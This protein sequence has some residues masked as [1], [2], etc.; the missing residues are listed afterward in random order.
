MSNN[1]TVGSV[2]K[3]FRKHLV[4]IFVITSVISIFAVIG[5]NFVYSRDG[6]IPEE[7]SKSITTEVT[8]IP[9]QTTT[10]EKTETTTIETT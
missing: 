1:E 7:I 9:S 3:G 6:K 5:V 10:E 4:N 8:E 2:K